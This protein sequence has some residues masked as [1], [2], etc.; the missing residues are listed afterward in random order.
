M[1]LK[2]QGQPPLP[3]PAHRSAQV[4]YRAVLFPDN[5][6]AQAP[7]S[8][9]VI[10]PMSQ[11]PAQVAVPR[12][13]EH[14]PVARP[15]SRVSVRPPQ[16]VLSVLTDF[17]EIFMPQPSPP[18]GKKMAMSPKVQMLNS[19]TSQ[20][21][22]GKRLIQMELPPKAHL[23]VQLFESVRSKFRET[24][25][26]ALSMDSDQQIGQESDGN[27]PPLGS[28]GE[29]SQADGGRMQGITTA[30]QDA[31]KDDHLRS[32]MR[33]KVRGDMQQ[34]TEH[35]PFGNK[36]PGNTS[37]ALDDHLQDHG[38][39]WSPVGA[40]EFMSQP[41][42][43]KTKIS[44][45][46]AGVNVSQIGPESK[47]AITTDETTKEKKVGIHKGESLAFRIEEELFKLFGG[48]NKKYKEKGRS[49]LF[50]L[51]DK[52][53]SVLRE[54]VLSGGITPKCLCAMTI[55]ELASKELS[56]WRMAKAE[57]LANMVVL[58]DIEVD[59]RR[60]VR[61]THKGEF[62]VEVDE[63]DVG[64]GGGSLSYVPSKPIAVQTKIVDKTSVHKEVKESDN[65]V[66][67]GVAEPCNSNTSG[68]F[69]YPANEKSDLMQETKPLIDDLQVS[70]NLPQIMSRDE[71]MQILHS[72]PQSEDQSD[73]AL[74]DDPSIDKAEKA[75]KSE[76]FPIAK[77]KAAAS[78]FQFHS[79]LGSPQ[80]NLESKLES[81]MKKSVSLL[82][83]VVEP[84]ADVIFKTP[85]EKVDAEKPDTVNG[86]IPEST[87]QCKITP[88]AALT[89]DSIWEGAIQ[90][91][92][93]SLT[94]IVAIFKSGE[95]PS[96]NE[97][98]RLLEIKR[99]VKL[100]DLKEFL[101]QL[102]KSRSRAIMVTELFS[103]EGLLERGWR[104]LLQ[105][106]DSYIA[107]GRVGLA[108]LAEGVE[109]YLLPE[110]KAA[111]I[112]ADHLPKERS[113][114][115]TVSQTSIIGLVVW[116]RPDVLRRV[117][118]KQDVPKSLATISSSVLP[119]ISQPP[120][121]SSNALR[122][123]QED[124]VTADVLPGVG[125]GAVKN[126][127][128]DLPEYDFGSV[129]DSDADVPP[130]THG[131]HQHTSV[132]EDRVKEIIRKYGNEPVAAQPWNDDGD[133]FA[134]MVR[135][136]GNIPE[137]NPYPQSY[138]QQAQIPQP[139]FPYQQQPAYLPMPEFHMSQEFQ[140]P[141]PW[142]HAQ[143]QHTG[144]MPV[145]QPPY[146][147]MPEFHMPREFQSPLPGEYAQHQHTGMMPV[148]QP[149]T[150]GH[151]MHPA[152]QSHYGVR[153][154]IGHSYFAG[155]DYSGTHGAWN[156]EGM[157]W[158]PW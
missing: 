86:L 21:S 15:S 40:S 137:W 149:P 126:D 62:Q 154:R 4:P 82:D 47:R 80:K 99:R 130:Q 81:P 156:P 93:T 143:H 18:S 44:D 112:L 7:A 155:R 84:K 54:R 23:Q 13:S 85:P 52:N 120:S 1:E 101:E 114:S 22:A 14:H 70:E 20:L 37:V 26:V 96:T 39:C 64:L 11:Q 117:A 45:V 140:S 144:M 87:M 116:R 110:G 19:P 43:K 55:E 128:E 98:C 48:V 136:Y 69:E 124:V 66:Q 28:S 46:Q 8:S 68:N 133:E 153:D 32:D 139:Q 31:G 134:R 103:K 57:E 5:R 58:P 109:L 91:T 38:L 73:G 49:L 152:Q 34:Q 3:S 76:S 105:T 90:L 10:V 71:L 17:P 59:V 129:S 36:V 51:N 135:K 142:E 141:L 118:N 102:P 146:H 123:H 9:V 100:S 106:I 145:H 61:K 131:S 60:L 16:Q 50:N 88:D 107:D 29:N 27:V 65:S 92:L 108:K 148:H 138:L 115:L 2:K 127:D 35:V 113:G 53:N 33:M 41:S 56:E 74:Q 125:P 6:G 150:Y 89:H 79:D 12:P 42:P 122:S 157:A 78:K 147:P 30:F 132:S 111:Q 151:L 72:K 158:H 95:K 119:R 83:P 24:L 67:D 104:H 94:N 121:P 63:T 77:D 97:W 75:L 25:A